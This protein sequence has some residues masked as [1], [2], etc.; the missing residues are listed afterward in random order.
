[1]TEQLPGSPIPPAQP[2][3]DPAVPG[4]VE[5]MVRKNGSLRV[6]GDF[7][8]ID[9]EGKPIPLPVGKPSVALCR[10]GMSQ[11]KPFCDSAHKTCG[12]IDPPDATAAPAAPA[13]GA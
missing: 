1:M 11:R 3:S 2:T 7:S 4:K 13:A 9:H 5:I 8:L 6:T 10:C 12:F